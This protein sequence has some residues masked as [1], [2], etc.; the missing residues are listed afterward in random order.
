MSEENTEALVP[1]ES[2]KLDER[3]EAALKYFQRSRQQA[4]SADTSAK[5]FRLFLSGK[6]THE[7][8]RLN[9][10]FSLGQIVH[11]RIK[12]E[13]DRRYREHMDELLDN[14]QKRVMQVTLE[15][16]NF[17]S[18]LITAA[19]A[20][21]GD[22]VKKYLQTRN[23]ADLGELQIKTLAGYK[24][25]I[26]LLQKLTGQDKQTKVGGEVVV[27]HK[28]EQPSKNVP[29]AEEAAEILKVLVSASSVK[30]E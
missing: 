4:L 25:A 8:H 17:V 2:D 18:D 22:A 14:T 6:T 27:T 28:T 12:G 16:I 24:L 15:S 30:K 29:S 26:E 13:W 19:N 7:I 5:L 9:Q 10:S 1:L 21:H 23:P 11:A 3:E 20:M